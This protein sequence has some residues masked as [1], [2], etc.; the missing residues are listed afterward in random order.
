MNDTLS[1]INGINNINYSQTNNFENYNLSASQ[2]YPELGSPSV[3]PFIS[4][5]Q[6]KEMI[7]NTVFHYAIGLPETQVLGDRMNAWKKK[8]K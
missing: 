6:D 2:L 1:E 3:G 5:I 7:R 8:M 4:P